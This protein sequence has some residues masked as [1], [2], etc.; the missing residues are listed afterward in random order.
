MESPYG[1][2]RLQGQMEGYIRGYLAIIPKI[3][4]Q[5]RKIAKSGNDNN[6]NEMDI[7]NRMMGR[8]S[9][10]PEFITFRDLAIEAKFSK[11]TFTYLLTCR[12]I[13]ITHA[14]SIASKALMEFICAFRKHVWKHRCMNMAEWERA[15]NITQANKCSTT[16][17]SPESA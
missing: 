6:I 2:R 7:V 9:S 11:L 5:V 4:M 10:S 17:S 13:S 15:H 14:Y 16:R 3:G 12:G 8:A 1:M